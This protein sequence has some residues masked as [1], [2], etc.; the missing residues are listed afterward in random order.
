MVNVNTTTAGLLI[1][2]A[3]V[4]TVAA[5]VPSSSKNRAFRRSPSSSLG[6]YICIVVEAEILP[7]R[8]DEFLDVM[9]KDAVG[10]RAE[11]GCLRFDVLQSQDDPNKFFFYEVYTDVDAV[12]FHKAQPHFALWTNFKASGGVVNSVSK[13]AEGVFMS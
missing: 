3:T 10:S 1:L 9:E 13:K 11:P 12:T 5:F 2:W 4:S 7:D 6:S 8:R